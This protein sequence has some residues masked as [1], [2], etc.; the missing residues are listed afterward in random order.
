MMQN[1]ATMLSDIGQVSFDRTSKNGKNDYNPG[2][3]A[4]R[5][6]TDFANPG[7]EVYNWNKTLDNSL[8]LFSQGKI[9]IM[10]GFAYHL[11]TIIA[12]APKLNFGIAKLPQ[13]EGSQQ[14]INFANYWIETVSNKSNHTNEAWNFIQFIT[15]QEE[16][17]SYLEQTKKPTALRALI[18][19]QIDDLD[20]GVFAEQLLTAKSWYKGDDANAVEKIFAEMIDSVT[21]GQGKIEDIIELAARKVQ[22]TINVK[23]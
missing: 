9:A 17:N 14:E 4:L 10:F 8:A 12:Q 22:Q 15:T 21:V 2:V 7:M 19:K 20:I 16:A 18:N 5:F 3:E 13:I 1:G 6:Y 23:K 11:P